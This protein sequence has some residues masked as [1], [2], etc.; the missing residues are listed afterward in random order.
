M[1][2]T[3]KSMNLQDIDIV[4][5]DIWQLYPEAFRQLLRDHTTQKNIYWATRDYEYL[6]ENYTF[7]AEIKPE[8]ITGENGN[9]IRPRVLK[10][11]A[12][13][14]SRSKDMAEVFTP[15]WVCNAQNNL[16]DEVW[17]GRK[18]V[19][20]IENQAMHTWKATTDSIKFPKGKSWV[21]YVS[22]KRLEF[23]CGEA[24]YLVSR[25][26]TTTGKFIPLQERIGMLDRKMRVISENVNDSETW[27]KKAQLAYMSI[28][29]YEWQGDN[30][31]LARE[32]LLISFIEYYKAKFGKLPMERSIRYMAY[33]ISWNIWQMDGLKGVLPDSCHD[34]TISGTSSFDLAAEGLPCEGCCRGDIHKHNGIYCLI[35]NWGV[36]DR[37]T[38]ERNRKVRFVDLMK[39]S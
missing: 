19:F 23:T 32:S 22:E 33:I 34:V 9:I 24:P 5:D 15:S 36:R 20:N 37:K 25:Y 21:N 35:R 38:G 16:V 6:G 4:E 1:Q 7:H 2:N 18:D 17:F 30:L 13:Q 26:D 31:L 12:I 27:L 8:L 28:Y 29:G 3:N 11:Q 14:S 10:G 39:Q